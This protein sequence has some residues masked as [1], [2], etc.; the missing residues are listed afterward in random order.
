MEQQ[1]PA[2]G[3]VHDTSWTAEEIE[4]WKRRVAAVKRVAPPMSKRTSEAGVFD[5]RG[6]PEEMDPA[7]SQWLSDLV[8]EVAQWGGHNSNYVV[9]YDGE[10]VKKF[11]EWQLGYQLK[12][13]KDKQP[14]HLVHEMPTDPS[15][16]W[17]QT[18]RPLA[19][20]QKWV[21]VKDLL[22][23]HRGEVREICGQW[24]L[25]HEPLPEEERFHH[26]QFS[27]TNEGSKALTTFTGKPGKRGGQGRL[28]GGGQ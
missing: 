28:R 13:L 26:A 18:R 14:A 15:G 7:T 10:G 17:D 19:A 16:H 22:H 3:G 4:E 23:R 8:D 5:K 11:T 2:S 21:F 6:P 12:M 9:A 1:E 25:V 24:K 27:L 20:E